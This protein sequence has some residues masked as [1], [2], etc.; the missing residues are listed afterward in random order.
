MKRWMITVCALLLTGAL[1]LWGS[2]TGI[3]TQEETT[4]R[5]SLIRVWIDGGE[6]AVGAWLKKCAA[7]Y[8][9][10]TGLRVYLRKAT[11]DEISAA[12]QNS[13]E[14]MPPDLLLRQGKGDI[15]V[16]LRGYALIVRDS[17]VRMPS[18]APT[19]ALFFRPSPPPDP[20]ASP[21]WPEEKSL[22]AVLVPEELLE[23]VPGSIFS[24]DPAADLF[25][26]KASAALLT[27]EQAARLSVGYR[28]YALP[29]GKGLLPVKAAPCSEQGSGFCRYLLTESSQR[30]LR[31]VGLFSPLYRLYA[32]D[33]PIRGQI[34]GSRFPAS[35]IQFE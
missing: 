20:A 33:D 34:D 11:A 35:S 15:T 2:D 13:L 23:C 8:E 18:P 9:K 10:E 6:P 24:A 31:S 12:E 30:I 26:G 27:A 28:V 5:F 3:K 7:A 16:A 25:Q 19:G 14:T 1:L 22:S 4:P 32:S 29:D 21:E 17:S